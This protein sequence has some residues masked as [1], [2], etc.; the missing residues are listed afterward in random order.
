PASAIAVE[1]GIDGKKIRG[2]VTAATPNGVYLLAAYLPGA[3]VVVMQVRVP[4]GA[5]ELTMAPELLKTIDLQGKIVTGDALFA[6]RHLSLQIGDAGGDYVW[7]VK[8]NQETLE[9]DI[10]RVFEP[11]PP[12][13]LGFSNPQPDFQVAET[14]TTGHGR[15][16]QRTLTTSRWL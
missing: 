4:A 12:A 14:I 13:P 16:A 1:M 3:G 5:G 9:R 15:I 7:K 10:A 2:T 8:G 11:D 6:Q